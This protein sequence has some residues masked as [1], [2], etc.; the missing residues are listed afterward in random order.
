MPRHA[1]VVRIDARNLAGLLLL[2]AAPVA[3]AAPKAAVL[4]SVLGS[5]THG[6]HGQYITLDGHQTHAAYHHHMNL[7][8]STSS[9]ILSV[10]SGT[11]THTHGGVVSR[12]PASW[13][14]GFHLRRADFGDSINPKRSPRARL[15]LEY[16][17]PDNP[18]TQHRRHIDNKGTPVARRR[19]VCPIGTSSNWHLVFI[20]TVSHV[21]VGFSS[22]AQQTHAH[23]RTR[24][25]CKIKPIA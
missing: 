12:P 22:T 15:P 16:P 20:Y 11:H 21:L 3:T 9:N 1:A 25:G 19:G 13:G 5:I 24:I 18:F 10:S 17:P 14:C 4:L 23:T 2:T 7:F 8:N 6:Q